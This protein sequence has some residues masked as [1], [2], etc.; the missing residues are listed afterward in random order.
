MG[1]E[2]GVSA[3]VG[4]LKEA[5]SDPSRQI[6]PLLK[7]A[8]WYLTKSI[9]TANGADFTK[10]NALYNAALVR[11][12]LAHCECGEDQIIKGIVETY[13][14]FSFTFTNDKDVGMD[15]ICN[16][17]HAHKEFLTEEREIF[18]KQLEHHQFEVFKN[19][20]ILV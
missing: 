8:D 4:Q 9:A 15:E 1:E 18:K 20:I 14:A 3:A 6:P 12:K 5:G 16:E 10:A 19:R 11:S 17:I 2:I 7:L 13:R